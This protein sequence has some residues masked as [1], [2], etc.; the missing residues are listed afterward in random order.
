MA[1]WVV[2]E[3]MTFDSEVVGVLALAF[4]IELVATTELSLVVDFSVVIVSLS[5]FEQ[6]ARRIVVKMMT[7]RGEIYVFFIENELKVP[8][9]Y[10]FEVKIQ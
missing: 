9:E 6:D 8:S 1:V 10:F 3:L 2:G 7:K 4:S 5:M